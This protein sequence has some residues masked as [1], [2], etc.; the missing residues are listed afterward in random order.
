MT[1]AEK[2]AKEK[3][4]QRPKR[5]SSQLSRV[6]YWKCNLRELRD[7]LGLTQGDICKAVGCSNKTLTWIERGYDTTLSLATSIATFFGKHISD[8][9]VSLEKD[10]RS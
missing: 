9:W 10:G 6:V 3:G 8:I 2:M 4:P 5:T 1:P 7:S